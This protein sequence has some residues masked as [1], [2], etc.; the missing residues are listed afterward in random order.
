MAYDLGRYDEAL[1]DLTKA[2][3]LDPGLASCYDSRA[4]A[5]NRLG[6]Y[7]EALKDIEKAIELDVESQY[8][9][10]FYATRGD[11][12]RGLTRYDD[13]LDMYNQAIELNDQRNEAYAGRASLAA[14]SGDYT[15][16][17][18]D[19]DRALAVPGISESTK[20]EYLTLRE[21]VLAA[22]SDPGQTDGISPFW[23]EAVAGPKRVGV[24]TMTSG[25]NVRAE[26]NADAALVGKVRSGETFDCV[27]V[28]ENTGWYRIVLPVGTEGYV[29]PKM[30]KLE[31]ISSP[32][33]TTQ[34]PSVEKSKLPIKNEKVDGNVL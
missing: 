30:A 31:E 28:D 26:G 6:R 18:E 9:P 25:S 5:L 29:S 23:P 4:F 33:P 8:T 16:A 17:L 22:Q 1:P 14:V 10:Y 27:A 19:I 20:A 2:L 32:I 15:T 12:L 24:V 34:S 7:E 21:A 3:E 13:A 11:V